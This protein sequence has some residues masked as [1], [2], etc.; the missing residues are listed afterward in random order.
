MSDTVANPTSAGPTAAG[1][2]PGNPPAGD[3]AQSFIDRAKAILSDLLEVKVVTGVGAIDVEITTD[4]DSTTTK[5][6]TVKPL[7][8]SI[9]TVVKIADGDVSTVISEG[10]VGNADLRAFHA[11]QVAKSLTVLPDNLRALVAVAKSLLELET[12][13]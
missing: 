3:H 6:N 7:Q 2:S 4:G 12:G 1:P 9:V 13:E 11:D 5:L 8:E 10:L